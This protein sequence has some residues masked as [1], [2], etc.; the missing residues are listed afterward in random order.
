MQLLVGQLF[1]MV[2]VKERL[3]SLP[4]ASRAV[5]VTVCAPTGKKL[6]EGGVQTTAM[7]V[8][9]SSTAATLNTTLLPLGQEQ[10]R[11]MLE[12]INVKCGGTKSTTD[13]YC[14]QPML[15]LVQQS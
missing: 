5:Q 9:Q 14:V 11:T 3:V 15:T 7:L 13:T 12:G 2:M 6:P 10:F 4:Q 8:S 1:R